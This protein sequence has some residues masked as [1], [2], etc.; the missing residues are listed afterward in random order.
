[1]PHN[2]ASVVVAAAVTATPQWSSE[3]GGG[4]TLSMSHATRGAD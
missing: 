3:V 2:K 4:C 1:L